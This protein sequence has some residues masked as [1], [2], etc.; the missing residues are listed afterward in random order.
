M[1]TPIVLFTY[2]RPWH[3]NE[4]IQALLRNK[5]S[6]ESVIYIYSDAF[7]NSKDKADVLEVRKLLHNI[8]GFKKT[9]LIERNFHYGL[10]N[11]V[12]DGVTKIIN[13][14]KSVIVLEDDLICS[15]NFL[16][17]MNKT[18]K[19]YESDK[20][21]FSVT[22][23]NYP[24]SI[25]KDY[26]YSVY[27]SYRCGSW[28]WGTWKD[29]WE[30]VDWSIKDY[31]EFKHDEVAQRQFNRGGE[32]LVNMLDYQ[33]RGY[34]DSW[35]I[36]WCYTHYKNKAY[37]IHP[38]VSKIKNIGLDGS[39]THKVKYKVNIKLDTG[40]E[41]LNLKKD[42]E[43]NN[44]IIGSFSSHFKLGYK[45]KMVGY[46]KNKVFKLMQLGKSKNVK[47]NKND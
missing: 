30:K 17:Y 4:T 19:F 1:L 26:P 14:H 8:K 21:I 43:I 35:A 3:T 10:A 36:R 22:G 28:G 29:R 44:E 18:L 46:L 33:M 39:G 12:I 24:I 15:Q 37:C 41:R 6:S 32:D 5:L 31:K 13:K 40:K 20:R 16:N 47:N 23:Y 45:G 42:I 11:S 7:K 2:K 25:P 9:I 38:T 34:I 27:L